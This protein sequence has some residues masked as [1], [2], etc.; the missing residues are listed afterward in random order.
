MS[1]L[2]PGFASLTAKIPPASW[3]RFTPQD[4]EQAGVELPGSLC[5]APGSVAKECQH[6]EDSSMVLVG[7]EQVQFREDIADVGLNRLGSHP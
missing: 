6:S 5:G 3:S 4:F 1:Y 2:I 7:G